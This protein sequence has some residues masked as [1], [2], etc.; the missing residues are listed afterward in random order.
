M[1]LVLSRV[2]IPITFGVVIGG[3]MSLWESRFVAKAA[4]W[5]CNATDPTVF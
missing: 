1:N 2:F 5:S 3:L 4:L